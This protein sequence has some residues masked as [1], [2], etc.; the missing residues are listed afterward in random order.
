MVIPAGLLMLLSAQATLNYLVLSLAY[1]LLIP[2]KVFLTGSLFHGSSLLKLV[3]K[4]EDIIMEL[5]F[6]NGFVFGSLQ[7]CI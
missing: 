5:L 6:L 3:C 7:L 2:D 1:K 4:L